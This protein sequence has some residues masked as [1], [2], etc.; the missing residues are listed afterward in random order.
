M[1]NYMGKLLLVDLNLKTAEE[2]KLD[3]RLVELFVG[4]KGLGAKLL[5]DL[6]PP[7]CEPLSPD[8]ILMF[9]AGPLTGTLAPATRGCVVTKSPLTGTFTDSYFGGHFAP[10]IRYAGYEGIVISG[11]AENPCYLWV[12]NGRVEIK[13]AEHLWGLDTFT[14]NKKIKEELKDRSVKVACIGPAG[15]KEVPFA[16][17][18][19]EYNRHAGRGGTGAVMGSKQLKAIALRGKNIISV[20][21]E[22]A[23]QAAVDRA[24][25]ELKDEPTIK[26]FT[27]DGTAG[28]IDF[29]NEAFLLPTRNYYDGV[30]DGADGLNA[31]AQRK[32][33]WLRDTACMGCPIACGKVGR[34]REGRHRGL[35]SDVVEYE[36]AAM[37]GSNLEI[38]DIR[39]VAYLAKKCDSLGLDGI[40]AGGVIG[41]AIEAFE[42]GLI[43]VEDTGGR[44]LKFN[45]LSTADYLLGIIAARKEGLGDIL[46]GGVKKASEAI[47]GNSCD[48]AVHVKGLES[49]AWG[50]RTVP[51][52]GLA[53]ATADRG[54][55][56]QRAFPILY[57]VDGIWEG[58]SVARLGLKGKG[59][60]V[61]HLQNYLAALDTLVKCDFAQYGIKGETYC[62]LLSAAT[63]KQWN[64]NNLLTLGERIWNLIRLF[65]IREGFGRSDDV[66]PARFMKEPLP[67]GPYK[68]SLISSQDLDILLDEY[69]EVRGW[70][71][72][73]KPSDIKLQELELFQLPCLIEK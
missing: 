50:P 12:D 9:L 58:K 72:E 49:P 47:G 36:V 56:H 38:S 15:E 32:S 33:F 69:Y 6:L 44:T 14:A 35:V 16:L 17:I 54:G 21:D 42:K 68:G 24:Y 22:G 45:D 62:Q 3:R 10:E 25:R 4:G 55:C 13:N 34:I 8:N 51:G 39:D 5:F 57:E 52:M 20:A 65:N 67:S 7:E 64:M 53:L 26:S 31:Q 59:G 23:F 48:F 11:R 28:S 19:C 60:I 71:N 63:G 29:A 73:G 1:S 30:F 37:M 66:L 27:L 18:N 46:S 2:F 61:A 70:D 40:S 41:F 43:P